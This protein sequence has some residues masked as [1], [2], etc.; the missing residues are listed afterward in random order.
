MLPLLSYIAYGPRR[1]KTS[2]REK[3]SSGFAN[4]EGADQ[5]VYPCI[6]YSHIGNSI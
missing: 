6:C 3:L 4:N 5:P 2:T 1:E